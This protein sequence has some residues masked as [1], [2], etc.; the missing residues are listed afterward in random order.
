[1]YKSK[2]F[3]VVVTIEISPGVKLVR[4]CDLVLDTPRS[5]DEVIDLV[6]GIDVSTRLLRLFGWSFNPNDLKY[7]IEVDLSTTTD[8]EER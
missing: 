5:R 8:R 1:M 4:H 6:S 7:E 2:N 3:R